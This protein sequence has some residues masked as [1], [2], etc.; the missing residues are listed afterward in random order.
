MTNVVA[1]LMQSSLL[2]IAVGAL[3]GCTIS[4][5]AQMGPTARPQATP[6]ASP[7]AATAVSSTAAA[8]TWP[9][10]SDTVPVDIPPSGTVESCF[11]RGGGI[12]LYRLTAPDGAS[13]MLFSVMI[14]TDW[15]MMAKATREND[16][17]RL[18]N[19]VNF[20]RGERSLDLIARPGERFLLAVQSGAA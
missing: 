12:D 3:A 7:A 9:D 8:C 13:P 15:Y 14:G 4:S 18:G 5:G 1:F 10:V 6:A 11:E 16:S 2:W 19:A 17:R 20:R